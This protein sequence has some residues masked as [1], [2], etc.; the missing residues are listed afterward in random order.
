MHI[1]AATTLLSA[2]LAAAYDLPDNLKTIYDNH[3]SGKCSNKLAGGFSDG[4]D[5]AH[6]FSYCADIDGTIYLHGS[7]NGGE[8]D[9]M[10]VDCDGLNDKGGDCGA[11]E[12]GQGETA[13]KDQLSQLGIEDLD[14]NVH[15]YVVF[16]N[17]N[18]DPQQYGMEPLSVM[19][20]VC[21]NQ[22]LYGIWGDTN[23]EDSTGEASI[24]LAQMCFPDD[25]INGNNGHGEEDVLYLGFT[26]KSAVPGSDADWKAGDR[27]SFED[28]IKELG[29]KLVAGLGA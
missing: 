1:L 26:G 18:F 9:N 15:P 22:V 27:N 8:Y 12:T 6:T 21:N 19:A 14:A 28:S 20:V 3:K 4:I 2:G 5:G 16:G 7:A 17:T 24:S 23:G 29:D 13:F 11:D 10:D 25:G